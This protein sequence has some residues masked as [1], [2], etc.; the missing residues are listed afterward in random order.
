MDAL[1]VRRP[2]SPHRMD[3]VPAEETPAAEVRTLFVS[4][5]PMDAKPRELYLL[6]R[7]Y[8]GYE[9]SLL[10]VTSKNGKTAS[11]VGFVTFSTRAGAEAAKQDLQQGVRFDPDMPQTIRLEFAKSNT[12]VSKPKQQLPPAAAPHPTMMHPF[13]GLGFLRAVE[14]NPAFFPGAP[15][16][17]P[18][19][20][21][22]YTPAD[23]PGAAGL[24]HHHA[25][26]PALQAAHHAAAAQVPTSLGLPTTATDYTMPPM[27]SSSSA[28]DFTK[29]S[30]VLT[31]MT[32]EFPK[33]S[34]GIHG[35]SPDFMMTSTGSPTPPC[36]FPKTFSL[37]LARSYP[38][39][40][41]T[42]L[43]LISTAPYAASARSACVARRPSHHA[44]HSLGY[45]G[46]IAGFRSP[47]ALA[48]SPPSSS[49]R[50]KPAV[51]YALHSQPRAQRGRT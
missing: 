4:G 27:S 29:T 35:P 50:P 34:M 10:K 44:I 48:S 12:K 18:P 6:F 8:E 9:S 13:P 20:P 51:L 22:A 5:L 21:F 33:Q 3:V 47:S 26:F 11:P 39:F 31:T 37:G 7:A 42:S 28:S 45:A 36:D 15:D 24:Q 19:H 43:G 38:E 25:L 40:A 41:M 2:T 49:S 1:V 46:R 17:W 32:A 30:H 14:L 16:V 23:L